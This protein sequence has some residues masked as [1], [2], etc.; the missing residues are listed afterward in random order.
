MLVD[1]NFKSKSRF[2][3]KDTCL[4]NPCCLRPKRREKRPSASNTLSTCSHVLIFERRANDRKSM[5]IRAGK[6]MQREEKYHFPPFPFYGKLYCCCFLL[7]FVFMFY[8][9]EMM[10]SSSRFLHKEFSL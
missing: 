10:M 1:E 6:K 7:I 8:F 9:H 4:Q 3:S 2:K 5:K